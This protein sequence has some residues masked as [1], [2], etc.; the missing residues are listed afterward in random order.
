MKS[1]INKSSKIFEVAANR[2]LTGLVHETVEK[3]FPPNGGKAFVQACYGCDETLIP[4]DRLFIMFE[5]ER[6]V[7]KAPLLKSNG[8][9]ELSFEEAVNTVKHGANGFFK[10]LDEG[11]N[12]ETN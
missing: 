10:K 11:E 9:S 4:R 5:S 1:L 3:V 2:A 6:G 8:M 7:V 12:D